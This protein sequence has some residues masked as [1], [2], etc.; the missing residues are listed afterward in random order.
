MLTT[1]AAA[2]PTNFPLSVVVQGQTFALGWPS[3]FGNYD[4]A[5]KINLDDPIWTLI[6][7]VTN[8]YLETPMTNPHKFFRLFP[9][10]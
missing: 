6:P 8:F 3:E 4:L 10:L 1:I 2:D 5:A 9:A 7:G